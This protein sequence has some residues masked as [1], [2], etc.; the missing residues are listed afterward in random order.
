[1]MMGDLKHVI[2]TCNANCVTFLYCLFNESKV[3]FKIT[4][5]SENTIIL[6]CLFSMD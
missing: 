3:M 2:K 5:M 4:F 6:G 1:M